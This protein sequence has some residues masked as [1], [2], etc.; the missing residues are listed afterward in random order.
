MKA[1]HLVFLVLMNCCWAGVYSAYKVIGQSLPGGSII[2]LRF[3]LA[4]GCMLLIWPWL[5]GPAPRGRDLFYASL[6][7]VLDFV[8]AQR[9]Q[10][11][12]N[13]IGSAGNSCVLM[14]VQPLFTSV[15]AALF[16]REHIGPRRLGGFGL[17]I[18][19]VIILNRVWRSDFQWAGLLPSLIFISTFF[20]ET[21]YSILGKPIVTR[22]S[23]AKTVAVSLLA[24]TATNL[25]IDGPRTLSAAKSLP[26]H[27][28]WL[29]LGLA[30]IC[31]VVGYTLWLVVIRQCPVNVAVLTVFVQPICG[32]ALAAWW[33]GE[34][35]HWGHI[36]GSLTILAGLILGLSRQIH[37]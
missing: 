3:A 31:T 10:I 22:A 21:A 29:L 35:A 17:S 12:A 33:L 23:G 20:C 30:I 15:A 36:L 34:P 16:L 32:V 11:Y 13:A 28:W 24:A 8:I 5:Q 25:L 27:V 2:T 9:L 6:M 18:L 37:R 4:A 26:P 7:G 1:R 14:A 19:G